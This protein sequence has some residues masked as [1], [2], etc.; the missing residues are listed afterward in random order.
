MF[1]RTIEEQFFNHIEDVNEINEI[2]EQLKQYLHWYNFTKVHNGLN[3]I[4]PIDFINKNLI[5]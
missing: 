5:N 1:N 2:N 3:Y 4:T